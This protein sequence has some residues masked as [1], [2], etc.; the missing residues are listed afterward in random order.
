MTFY[1]IHISKSEQTQKI[2]HEKI[3][4]HIRNEDYEYCNCN[5]D[6]FIHSDLVIILIAF[7]FVRQAFRN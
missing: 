6:A 7:R 3:V 5:G 1:E 2:E 4:A